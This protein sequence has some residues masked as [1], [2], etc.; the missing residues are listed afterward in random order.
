MN[1][2]KILKEDSQAIEFLVKISSWV[3][4]CGSEH[5]CGCE[6]DRGKCTVCLL[7]CTILWITSCFC[8]L[9]L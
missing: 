5:R 4:L 3:L 2:Y 8:E 6:A 9:I 7:L 1:V